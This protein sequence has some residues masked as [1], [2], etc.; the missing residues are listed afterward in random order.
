MQVS[1]GFCFFSMPKGKR[2]GSDEHLQKF[3]L[4]GSLF[5]QTVLRPPNPDI[6]TWSIPLDQLLRDTRAQAFPCFSYKYI[7]QRE[8]PALLAHKRLAVDTLNQ[9]ILDEI[10]W[11]SRIVT[12]CVDSK[13]KEEE[14]IQTLPLLSFSFRKIRLKSRLRHPFIVAFMLLWIFRKQQ[15][16]ITNII[17]CPY[18]RKELFLLEGFVSWDQVGENLSVAVKY[19]LRA[20]NPIWESFISLIGPPS[21]CSRMLFSSCLG[22]SLQ[23]K[24]N[25]VILLPP[26]N[27]TSF[28]LNAGLIQAT[29]KEK[30]SY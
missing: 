17:V 19:Y 27:Q 6:S 14:I 22:P 16:L 1:R 3:C 23:L 24:N 2:M 11:C 9:K 15:I 20:N 29:S 4:P 26:P 28:L 13:E 5:Q 10:W 7:G 8:T 21:L 12:N 25:F 30:E 18:P